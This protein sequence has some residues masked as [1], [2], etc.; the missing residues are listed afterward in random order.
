M[1]RADFVFCNSNTSLHSACIITGHEGRGIRVWHDSNIEEA[2]LKLV[3]PIYKFFLQS[4]THSED[5]VG[6]LAF[7]HLKHSTVYRLKRHNFCSSTHCDE[8]LLSHLP[9]WFILGWWTICLQHPWRAFLE[10]QL[11]VEADYFKSS[12]R[13]LR[14][15]SCKDIFWCRKSFWLTVASL[16]PTRSRGGPQL[17]KLNIP[18]LLIFVQFSSLLVFLLLLILDFSK[19][20]DQATSVYGY[21]NTLTQKAFVNNPVKH[22]LGPSCEN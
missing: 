7:I 15:N 8:P 1:L 13:K 17:L 11:F 22:G 3:M 6:F 19:E 16:I 4:A 18:F 10:T 12:P 9:L 20:I 2:W 5:G 21:C 14:I